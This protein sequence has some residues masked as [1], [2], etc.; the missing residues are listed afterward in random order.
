MYKRLAESSNGDAFLVS[1][2]EVEKFGDIIPYALD[3]R[4]KPVNYLPPAKVHTGHFAVDR[5]MNKMVL[6]VPGRNVNINL[7]DPHNRTHR[8]PSSRSR[9]SATETTQSVQAVINTE[10]IKFIE[11]L[12]PEVGLWTFETESETEHSVTVSAMTDL[13]IL[14]GFAKTIPNDIEETSF[15]PLVNEKNILVVQVSNVTLITALKFAKIAFND[16]AKNFD[17][18]L[19]QAPAIKGMFVSDA[20][21]TPIDS[22][23]IFVSSFQ[24]ALFTCNI[25]VNWLFSVDQRNGLGWK[26][27]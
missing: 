7:R 16:S 22:F 5:S 19:K 9:R 4:Y 21:K 20:F 6:S 2:S 24:H 10:N 18:P 3:V 14:Y 13:A 1:P 12:N 8:I 26:S 17:I 11:I 27:N 23:K 15:E 25:H